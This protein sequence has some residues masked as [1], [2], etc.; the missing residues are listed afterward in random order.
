MVQ[1]LW[2]GRWGKKTAIVSLLC[3]LGIGFFT[4]CAMTWLT[5]GL[6]GQPARG[7]LTTTRLTETNS[8]DMSWIAFSNELNYEGAYPFMGWSIDKV[9]LKPFGGRGTAEEILA[10]EGE[11]PGSGPRLTWT[12]PRTLQIAVSD[13]ES[14]KLLR[15]DY[16]GIHVV[17]VPSASASAPAH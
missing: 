2:P 11:G 6:L 5:L 7:R 9:Y 17:V 10:T 12:S 1:T 3:L 13:P 15:Q 14:A 4:Y 8:Q 16:E